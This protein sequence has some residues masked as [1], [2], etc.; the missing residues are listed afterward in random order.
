MGMFSR[1]PKP[2]D[3]VFEEYRTAVR[4]W[5]ERLAKARDAGQ[6]VDTADGVITAAGNPP[7]LDV[8]RL[9]S[10]VDQGITIEAASYWLS[11]EA[12]RLTRQDVRAGRF[13]NWWQV[14]GTFLCADLPAKPY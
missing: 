2:Q 4:S 6:D 7:Q 14:I 1:K 13:D 12:D 9:S 3:E 8:Q 11:G 5:C 10:R